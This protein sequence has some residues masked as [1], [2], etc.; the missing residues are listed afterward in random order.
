MLQTQTP[1]TLQTAADTATGLAGLFQTYPL[2]ETAAWVVGILLLAWLANNLTRRYILKVISRLVTQTKFTWDDVIFERKVFRRLAH[3]A[4]AIVFYYGA[5]MVPGIPEDFAQLVQRVSMGFMVLVVVLSVDGLLSALNDIYSTRPDA[6]SR[7]IKGYLQIVKIVLYIAA[8]ILVISTLIGQNPVAILTGFGAMTA[9]LLL[10]FK[11]TILSL[12]ASVQITQY[13]MIAVGD[14]I[15]MPKYGADGDV[16]DIALHTITIQNF[17]KT[18]TTIPTHKF[19]EDSFKNWRGMSKSGGRRIKRAL[20]LDAGTIRFLSEEEVDRFGRFELLRDYMRE[21][22]AQVDTYNAEKL[23]AATEAAEEEEGGEVIPNTRRFTN[24]GTFRAYVVN[25]LRQHP[26]V[27]QGMTLLVRQ[28]QSGPNGLPLE[29]YVFSNDTDWIN[30]EGFQ[31][32]IFDHLLAMVPEFG[33]RVFQSPSGEDVRSVGQLLGHG[34][35]RPQGPARPP[36][37]SPQ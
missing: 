22:R 5:P 16:I 7:P 30:Y 1:D 8:G 11:D 14:W 27:N 26:M 9:V 6:K 3:I 15:E 20:H 36:E 21:K 33:L 25:Y 32:D 18:I 19:I 2:V 23:A 28:L 12:V 17:D 13:D 37:P 34:P 10:V 4:P 24:V 35:A 31:S 29:V